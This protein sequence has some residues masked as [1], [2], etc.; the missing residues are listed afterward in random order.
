MA[1]APKI[2]GTD[3]LRQAYPK[4]NQAIELVNNYQKQ[5]DEIVVEGDSSVESAQARVEEDGTVNATLKNRLDKKEKEFASQL[6]EKETQIQQVNADITLVNSKTSNPLASA[7]ASGEKVTMALLSEEVQ[8][9][10]IGTTPIEVARGLDNNKGSLF[11]LKN[12]PR[13][14]I[15]NTVDSRINNIFLSAK[16]TGARPDKFYMIEWIGNG[17]VENGTT[18]W[19]MTISEYTRNVQG[20]ID[21]STR[22]ELLNRRNDPFPQ[23]TDTVVSR[24]ISID[25]GKLTFDIVYD[26]SEFT[27][28]FNLVNSTGTD[29]VGKGCVIHPDN[30]S[31]RDGYRGLIRNFGDIYPLMNIADSNWNARQEI[32]IKNALLDAKVFNAQPGCRYHLQYVAK[33]NATYGDLVLVKKYNEKN[34]T[35]DLFK[36]AKKTYGVNY[37]GIDTLT[38]KAE[39]GQEVIQLTIDYSLLNDGETINLANTGTPNV[40]GNYISPSNLQIGQLKK[41]L[42]SVDLANNLVYIYA[43]YGESGCIKFE[44]AKKTV[45]Q[46]FALYGINKNTQAFPIKFDVGTVLNS[47]AT[48]WIGPYIVRANQNG[49]ATN[50]TFTGGAHSTENTNNTG[51]PTATTL[52]YKIV[53]DGEAKEASGDYFGDKIDIIVRNKIMSYNTMT[54]GRHTHEE[55]VRYEIKGSEIK[56]TVTIVPLE[57]ITLERYYGMQGVTNQYSKTLYPSGQTTSYIDSNSIATSSGLKPSYP[58]VDTILIKSNSGDILEMYLE[59]IGL[60]TRKNVD[61]TYDLAF[62]SGSKHYFRQVHGVELPLNVGDIQFW[63]GV[64]TFSQVI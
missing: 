12:V 1:D 3:S 30:Y 61:P 28:F 7:A 49:D 64:Y 54:A 5:I 57:S 6:A 41:N 29:G 47:S 16:V 32:F 35:T 42:V 4:L 55:F 52:D 36:T 9:A 17:L 53:V 58:M 31:Y 33:N 45:N 63:R 39:R 25:N 22:R 15:L 51:N 2:L 27:T 62:G 26:R 19:G 37:T 20:G 44:F 56:V 50:P 13:D 43:K 24:T 46:L 34:E 48:D 21:T 18:Y 11:P 59:P 40:N 10:I 60:G 23:T 14:N 8:Q 38:I